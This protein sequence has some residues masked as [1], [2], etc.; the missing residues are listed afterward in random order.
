MTITLDNKTVHD[1]NDGSIYHCA[2]RRTAQ[3]RA[4]KLA[5]Q[6]RGWRIS[7]V[8]TDDGIRRPLLLAGEKMCQPLDGSLSD[9]RAQGFT[10]WRSADP[11]VSSWVMSD[12]MITID[13]CAG[14]PLVMI[15]ERGD[16]AE[17]REIIEWYIEPIVKAP[18]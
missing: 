7:G 14:L 5:L 8:G 3:I 6:E 4:A 17:A 1:S 9:Q 11:Q 13:A 12:D 10:A 18:A 16:T 2:T 15:R